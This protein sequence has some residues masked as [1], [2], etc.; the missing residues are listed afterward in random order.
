MDKDLYFLKDTT[1][2]E[3]IV[4]NWYAHP[5]LI[6]P[7]T[8][9]FYIVDKIKMMNSFIA[10]PSLHE[11]AISDPTTRGRTFLNKKGA[12][13]TDVITLLELTLDKTQQQQ[14]F[15][16]SVFVLN[17]MLLKSA[18]GYSMES[19]YAA[20]PPILKGFVEL[21]YDLNNQ[22]GFRFFE[23]LLYHSRLHDT[24][25][26]SLFLYTMNPTIRGH[27]SDTPRLAARNAIDVSMSFN[28]KK[29]DKLSEMRTKPSSMAE[30]KLLLPE[31]SDELIADLFTPKPPSESGENDYEG[32]GVRIRYFGHAC[33][34]L[35][36]SQVSILIDPFINYSASQS[37]S[38]FNFS[39]LP[40]R[41]DYILITHNHADHIILEYLLQLKHKT[42]CIVVP[43]NG[44]GNLEDPSLKLLLKSIGFKNV[45]EL[46]ELEVISVPGGDITGL[47][48][49]GE[50]CDLN[51]RSKIL[52]LVKLEGKS[53]LLASDSSNLEIQVYKH[54][55]QLIGTVDVVFLGMES[56]GAPLS[57]NYG[58]FMPRALNQKMDHS[59][60][61]NGSDFNS[62]Y[63]IIKEFQPRNVYIYAMGLEPWTQYIL[64]IS[65]TEESVQLQEAEKLI[66]QCLSDG[67]AAELLEYQKEVFLL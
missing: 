46:D 33:V 29:V 36:S 26:Q 63:A 16:E 35:Q 22:P 40:K 38:N 20:V 31:I 56:E 10:D 14:E 17:E 24:S 60:R 6:S 9:P 1:V 12:E 37:Q 48:F 42:D 49:L 21:L 47:P 43:R 23:S 39:D 55:Q 28:D 27:I 53:F 50:H 7:T 64:G 67:L 61:V 5:Y 11:M 32:N 15:A 58:P 62:G 8:Q 66:K 3:P 51:I 13:I 18:D 4:W 34:L 52:H 57:L 59:R 65:Y 45:L 2:I 44:N 19:L 30:I 54:I 41:I 25:G